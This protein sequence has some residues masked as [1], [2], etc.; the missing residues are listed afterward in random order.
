MSFTPGTSVTVEAATASGS[1]PNTTGQAFWTGITQRGPVGVNIQLQ[2]LQ[3]FTTLCGGR[4]AASPLY[5]CADLFFSSTTGSKLNISRVVGPAAAQATATLMDRAVTPLATLTV[6]AIGPGVDGNNLAVSVLAGPV[7]GVF[8]IQ[9]LYGGV[10]VETSPSLATPAD[11]ANWGTLNPA[12]T[13]SNASKW[14]SIT[15]L[16]NATAAPA[17]QPA[18]VTA[19]ALTAGADDNSNVTD[20]IYTAALTVFGS[21]YGPGQVSAPGRTTTATL[22][23]VSAHGR[24]FNRVPVFDTVTGNSA[25]SMASA[26]ATVQSAVVD[27]SYGTFITALTWPGVPTGTAVPT[28]PR[29]IPGSAAFAALCAINDATNDANIACAGNNGIL[30][31]AVGVAQAFT[32]ADRAVLNAAGINPF[33]L[34]N[35]NVEL[36]GWQ[37]LAVDPN[38]T[39]LSSVRFRMQL[40]NDA[41]IVGNNYDFAQVDGQGTVISAY[42]GDLSAMLARYYTAG[43]LYGATA[44]DAYVVDTGPTVNTAATIAARQLLANIYYVDS[45]SAAQVGISLV[46]FLVG[47]SLPA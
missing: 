35:G 1:A 9:V 40:T 41:A 3:D 28:F 33:I 7:S 45:P 32:D 29:T 17:N 30:T 19:T 10:I 38:W 12:M 23:G 14:V 42:N 31:R 24:A 20:A 2:S 46:K 16:A 5:D 8:V 15:N 26:A 27:P 22:T 37:S 25:S 21:Q 36:F 43:S 34:K 44:S 47:A 6:K 4:I 11:A 13:S 39:D 18:L